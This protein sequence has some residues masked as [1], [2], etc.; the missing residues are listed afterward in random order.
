MIPAGGVVTM[1]YLEAWPVDPGS[2]HTKFI[3]AGD[4]FDDTFGNTYSGSAK[5][6]RITLVGEARF[7]EGLELPPSF[8]WENPDLVDLAGV[9]PSTTDVNVRL[10]TET[11]TP[12]VR[13][14][15]PISW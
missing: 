10:P 6:G 15:Y 4:A 7:Y 14:E 8:V 5:H 3:D 2:R 13:R 12:V 1:D 9:I 11:A